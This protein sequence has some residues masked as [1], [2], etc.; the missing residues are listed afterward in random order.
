MVSVCVYLGL[1]SLYADGRRSV[2]FLV[3]QA[4][5]QSLSPVLKD[6]LPCVSF[7]HSLMRSSYVRDCFC[8]LSQLA[9]LFAAS[10]QHQSACL[11][12]AFHLSP[13]V[14]VTTPAVDITNNFTGMEN[15]R[16]RE[17]TMT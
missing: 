13:R 17:R 1:L 10:S 6:A 9:G 16:E 15:E 14:L 3:A 2:S 4:S 7:R 11:G 5:T 8:T 12:S